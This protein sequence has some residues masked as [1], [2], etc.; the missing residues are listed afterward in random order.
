MKGGGKKKKNDEPIEMKK[1]KNVFYRGLEGE[2]MKELKYTDPV[3]LTYLHSRARRVL[4]RGLKRKS[5]RF[6]EKLEK[7][8][9]SGKV[10][11]THLRNMLVLPEMIG[12]RVAVYNGKVYYEVTVTT[13]M[14]GRYLGEFSRTYKGGGH[15]RPGIGSNSS[16][17]FMPL[18]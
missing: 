6:L 14:V 2:K 17:R 8:S 18:H 13:D 4:Q 9:E 12:K 10:V 15:G 5:L 16:Q 1:E 11:K 7:N 3:L